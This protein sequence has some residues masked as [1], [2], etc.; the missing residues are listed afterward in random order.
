MKEHK[1]PP[2]VRTFHCDQCG[3][4]IQPCE[5]DCKP[6]IRPPLSKS[7]PR[8]EVAQ[9]YLRNAWVVFNSDIEQIAE[10]ETKLKGSQDAVVNLL[11]K[12]DD[13]VLELR[14]HD[15]PQQYTQPD[16]PWSTNAYTYTNSRGTTYVLHSRETTLKN[17]LERTL[18]YFAKNQRDGFMTAV[19]GGYQVVET[20][21]GLPVL[22]KA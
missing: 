7:I 22:K 12:I 21:N 1:H 14:E 17:G 13:L 2:G 10:L 5:H 9:G 11:N 16:S 19:P 6:Y 4:E 3:R 15:R 20:K 8:R 18:Y